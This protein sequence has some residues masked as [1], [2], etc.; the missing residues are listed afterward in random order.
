MCGFI[1]ALN[2]FKKIKK[3]DFINSASLIKHRGPDDTQYFFNDQI[4]VVF[5][6][7]SIRDRSNKGRQP[8][9]SSSNRYILT[10][11]GEIYNIGE[12]KKKLKK[13]RFNGNSDTE[14]LTQCFEEFGLKAVNYLQGMFS[15]IIYDFKKKKLYGFRDRLGIKP[16]YYLD[17]DDN[18]IFCSEIKPLLNYVKEKKIDNDVV[19][20]FFFKGFLSHGEKTFFKEINS[21]CP[22]NIIEV[23]KSIKK[24]SFYNLVKKEISSISDYEINNLVKNSVKSHLISDRKI[25]LFLSGGTDSTI[26][27]FLTKD[28]KNN[29]DVFTYDFQNYNHG[30]SAKSKKIANDLNLNFNKIVIKPQD[31]QNNFDNLIKKIESPITSIRLFGVDSLYKL[32]KKKNIKFLTI[33]NCDHNTAPRLKKDKKLKNLIDNFLD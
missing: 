4:S 29:F 11:N 12:L 28:I 30:E 10:F 32:A 20:D 3:N 8:F 24:K 13:K 31:V 1:F 21:V 22:G 33:K 7:L 9:F 5:H 16:L 18:T 27:S 17:N 15:I 6:R 26:L 25:G 19:S 2:K 14:V 23:S